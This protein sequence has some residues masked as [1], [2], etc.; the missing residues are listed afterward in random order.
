MPSA[1]QNSF[2]DMSTFA[3]AKEKKVKAQQI[4]NF[5]RIWPISS[6]GNSLVR[7]CWSW[8]LY[9]FRVRSVILP[10]ICYPHVHPAINGRIADL[11]LTCWFCW[12]TIPDDFADSA[13][14]LFLID[15]GFRN[16][17]F[18]CRNKLSCTLILNVKLT[19]PLCRRSSKKS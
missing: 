12:C 15:F 14:A 19:Q 8:W 7:F 11:T 18:I 5:G 16:P 13:D 17:S 10:F 9:G 1:K 6:M 2:L 3:L 4:K